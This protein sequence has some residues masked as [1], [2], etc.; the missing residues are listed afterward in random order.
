MKKGIVE[1]ALELCLFVVLFVLV[2]A[3]VVED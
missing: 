1:D 2:L 3:V